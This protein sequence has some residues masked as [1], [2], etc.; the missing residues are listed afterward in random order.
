MR[1]GISKEPINE[2]PLVSG[3]PDT[4]AK[5][6]KL[7][8]DVVV[9]RGAGDAAN[10][11]DNQY[12]DAGAA[13][14]DAEELWKSDIVT[15]IDTPSDTNIDRMDSG[16]TLIA[17]LAPNMHPE[18]IDKLAEK[19]LT[20]LALDMVPRISRAQS[21]DVRSSMMNVAG[22]R[23]VI[24]AAENYGKTFAGQITAA[25][26]V[27]PAKVYVIG[28]GVAGLAAIGQ[29]GSMGAQ[30]SA[31][32][33]RSDVADQVESLGATF[34]E[35]PVSQESSDGY[36]KA[37]TEDQQQQV[38]QVYTDEAAKNDIVITT[39]QVPGR[40]APLLI[41]AEA[42]AG[43]KPGSVIVDMGASEL[44]GNCELSKP[45]EIVVTDNG[46][47]IIG[48]TDLA[49]RMPGQS[50]QLFGQN[51]VNLMKLA[52]PGKDGQLVLD[53]ED[54]VIRGMTVTL[55]GQIMWPPPPVSV[56]VAPTEAKKDDIS[57]EEIAS[58]EQPQNSGLWWKLLIGIIFCGLIMVAPES[59]QSHFIVFALACVVGFYV[60]TGVSHTLHTPLMSVTNAISGIII[61][62]AILQIGS[63]NILVVVLSFIA[64]VIASINIFGGFLVT[65]RMLGMFERSSEE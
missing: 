54:D 51:I 39:A 35:I 49:S 48:Y 64:M 56:S 57:V 46:V 28:V 61:V 21:M 18:I 34:V 23:A 55:D 24:E 13:I 42:V 52:T 15:C 63:D 58:G 5:L 36:A 45:N 31:T 30:V 47:T 9:E 4:V 60:I 12:E 59:M 19:G 62:G 20:G 14:V 16:S 43:M 41:T 22:Y 38:L 37:L 25:G 27:P 44:G 53:E 17:R 10:Y 33:V 29:A 2:T 40:P 32:D 50:S 1:I 11:F 7:G 65:R 26:K 3:T 6:I 8:Y